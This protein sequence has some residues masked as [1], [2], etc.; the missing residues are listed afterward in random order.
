MVAAGGLRWWATFTLG[1]ALALGGWS[2]VAHAGDAAP[3]EGRRIA[4]V[5]GV[6]SYPR[7]PADLALASATTDAVRVA[8]ALQDQA[9]FDEVRLLTDASATLTSVESTLREQ[10]SRDVQWRDLL[11]VYFVGH[12]AGG[13]F[14]DPRLLLSDA[15]PAAL[16]RGTLSVGALTDLL[17][18]FVPASHYIIVTDAAHTG[19]LN[20]LALLGPTGA[21]WPS[22]GGQSLVISS[23]SP[24]QVA[25]PGAFATAFVEAIGGRADIDADGAVTAAELHD[26]LLVAVPAAT[27]GQQLPTAQRTF[28]P[29]LVLAQRGTSAPIVAGQRVDKAKFVFS[30]GTN[31]TVI[32]QGM[33]TPRVCDPACYVWDVSTGPCRVTASTP[34]GELTGQVSLTARGAY[35]C[36]VI[37]GVGAARTLQCAPVAGAR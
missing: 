8:A 27:N 30:G 18:K 31:T 13:D 16:E 36:T 11:L 3:G 1:W 33:T 5:I 34:G 12:G 24:R 10:L 28:P 32:C 35:T 7:L 26:Y 6:S 4:L 37:E 15:D 9:G 22:L 20:G 14:G 29:G 19:A 17:T 21:D 25:I 23:T 2:D